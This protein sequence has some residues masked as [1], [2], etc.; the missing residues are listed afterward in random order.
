[1]TEPRAVA[2]VVEEVVSG[3]WHWRI[4]DERIGGGTSAA[5]AVEGAGGVVLIDPLPLAEEALERLGPVS[6]ICVTAQCHQ[7]SAWRCRARFGAPVYAPETRP[8]EEEPDVRYRTGDVLPGDLRVIHTP[9]PEEAHYSFLLEHGPGVL[10]CSDILMRDRDGELAFVPFEY[11][12]DPS[13]TRRSVESLLELP[14]SVLCLDHGAPLVD[15]PKA[16]IRALLA[17]G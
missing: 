17:A 14:F 2:A 13:R 12:D 11:Q 7:R 16:A 5:H 4:A 10:F 6:A 1:M 8:M 3:V 15:D 9:G